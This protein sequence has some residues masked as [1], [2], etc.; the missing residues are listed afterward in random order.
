[1]KSLYIFIT[2]LLTLLVM[3]ACE[4]ETTY[5]TYENGRLPYLLDVPDTW[6][7]DESDPVFIKFQN[8]A[9]KNTSSSNPSL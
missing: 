1:M 8:A 4:Q 2:T 9:A 7:M 5:R 6:E 3:T